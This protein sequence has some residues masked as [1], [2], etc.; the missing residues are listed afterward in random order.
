MIFSF[1]LILDYMSSDLDKKMDEAFQFKRMESVMAQFLESHLARLGR[2]WGK[3]MMSSK[4]K[5]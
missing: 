1:Q 4:Q 3:R 2:E 5:Q